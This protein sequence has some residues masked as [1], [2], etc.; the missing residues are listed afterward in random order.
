MSNSFLGLK[1][2]VLRP[3]V[4]SPLARSPDFWRRVL[5]HASRVLSQDETIDLPHVIGSLN[6][7]TI[8]DLDQ[9]TKANEEHVAQELGLLIADRIA[10]RGARA[11]TGGEQRRGW[12]LWGRQLPTEAKSLDQLLIDRMRESNEAQKWLEEAQK[13]IDAD[14]QLRKNSDMRE[15][16]IDDWIFTQGPNPSKKNPFENLNK[17]FV[18]FREATVKVLTAIH[19]AAGSPPDYIAR[20]QAE[21]E[22]LR[23]DPDEGKQRVGRLLEHYLVEMRNTANR[24][25]RETKKELGSGDQELVA[26]GIAKSQIKDKLPFIPLPG[27]VPVLAE[28]NKSYLKNPSGTV[29]AAANLLAMETVAIA[30]ATSQG[31]VSFQY[32]F[33]E[34]QMVRFRYS[35]KPEE[36]LAYHILQKYMIDQKKQWIHQHVG[37]LIKRPQKGPPAPPNSPNGLLADATEAKDTSKKLKKG[38]MMYQRVEAAWNKIREIVDPKVIDKA[39]KVSVR[40]HPGMAWLPGFMTGYRA[41]YDRGVI[42]IGMCEHPDQ[43]MH[44][45]GHHIEDQSGLRPWLAMQR[46]LHKRRQG[47]GLSTLWMHGPDEQRYSGAMPMSGFGYASKYYEHGAT[48]LTSMGLEYLWDPSKAAKLY[49]KDPERFITFLAIAQGTL[50]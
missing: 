36:L 5:A 11:K 4:G 17:P 13:I 8:V 30:K 39:G 46:I 38:S 44:E 45:Y 32:H 33:V 29:A 22:A 16:L 9:V 28:L 12:F 18:P 15:A 6:I 43:I 3:A 19:K 42:N 24:F 41:N 50:G 2:V 35:Q 23:H 27:G 1:N 20:I 7:E 25:V 26:A 47:S 34:S 14:P 48:E 40:V 31:D 10:Q 37:D 49:M 21:R